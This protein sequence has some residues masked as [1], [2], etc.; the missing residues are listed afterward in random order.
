VYHLENGAGVIE[1]PPT[2][3]LVLRVEVKVAR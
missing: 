2:P 3:G 1:G